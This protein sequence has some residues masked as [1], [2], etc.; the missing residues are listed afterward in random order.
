MTQTAAENDSLS[1][2]RK[3]L[4]RNI[5][6]SVA[7]HLYVQDSLWRYNYTPDVSSFTII[8]SSSQAIWF[9]AVLH[10][11]VYLNFLV[12]KRVGKVCFPPIKI[13]LFLVENKPSLFLT[14]AGELEFKNPIGLMLPLLQRSDFISYLGLYLLFLCCGVT[15]L[16]LTKG[17]MVMMFLLNIFCLRLTILNGP[18]SPQNLNRSWVTVFQ[19]WTINSYMF[20]SS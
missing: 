20:P 14:K 1:L 19:F 15:F 7:R 3:K 12:S 17:N 6:F 10:C 18:V 8:L 4:Y 2:W 13:D 9:P 11:P 16:F 5:F